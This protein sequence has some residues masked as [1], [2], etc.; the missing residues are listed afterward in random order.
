MI[1]PQLKNCPFCGKAAKFVK[2]DLTEEKVG[3]FAICSNVRCEIRTLTCW[4]P[5]KAARLWNRRAKV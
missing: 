3:W 5:E 4:T 1:F 2:D